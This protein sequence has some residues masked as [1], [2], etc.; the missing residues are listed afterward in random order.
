MIH[1][2]AGCDPKILNGRFHYGVPAWRRM[3]PLRM[4]ELV[5]V[6][7]K[8]ARY[9]RDLSRLLHTGRHLVVDT[10]LGVDEAL[11]E[12]SKPFYIE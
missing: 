11:H 12:I 7:R 4:I 9:R 8:R 10:G 2:N 5:I 3:S 1:T 6:W